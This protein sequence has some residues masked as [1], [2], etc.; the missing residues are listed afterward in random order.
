MLSA[1][2]ISMKNKLSSTMKT[3]VK[4]AELSSCEIKDSASLKNSFYLQQIFKKGKCVF[5]VNKNRCFQLKSQRQYLNH[6]HALN[7]WNEK[8]NST[9]VN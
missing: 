6:W 3:E 1:R 9:Q 7:F 2:K 8:E 5:K 4:I